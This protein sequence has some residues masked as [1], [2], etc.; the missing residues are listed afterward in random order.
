MQKMFFLLILCA[1][2]TLSC[3]KD[4]K[5]PTAITFLLNSPFELKYG[6]TSKDTVTMISLSID[7][8]I[9]DSRC[10]ADV[11]C[12]WEGNAEVQFIFSN[13]INQVKFIL[14]THPYFRSD[15]LIN[16]YRIKLISLKPYLKTA[17]DKKLEKYSAE[18]KIT[19]E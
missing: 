11:I 18:L 13:S 9:N 16:G 3:Q 6:E 7:S 17:L 2:L 4:P 14:N 8:I 1:F 10:P 12:V 15:S 5:D 19:K